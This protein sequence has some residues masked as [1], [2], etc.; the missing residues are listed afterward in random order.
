[1]IPT[2]NLEISFNV[3]NRDHL[4]IFHLPGSFLESANRLSQLAL[5]AAISLGAAAGVARGQAA[6]MK[7]APVER[8]LFAAAQVFEAQQELLDRMFTRQ[9]G[10]PE[11]ARQQ[12]E[13]SLAAQVDEIDQVCQLT[14]AQKTK[15]ELVGRGVIKRYLVQHE[16]VIEELQSP[17]LGLA[18]FQEVL[19]RIGPLQE[20]L[21]AGLSRDDSLLRK[22]LANTLTEE[23]LARYHAGIRE[24]VQARQLA[25]VKILVEMLEYASPDAAGR[26][27]R[28]SQHF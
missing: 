15:L 12:L 26:G 20:S 8:G 14:I 4:M 5:F 2:I 10:T 6:Q 24:R 1:M 7:P 21:K 23:Q 17:T 27:A 3:S 16:L 22:S 18:R 11:G 19:E 28:S 25:A 13:A 9:I